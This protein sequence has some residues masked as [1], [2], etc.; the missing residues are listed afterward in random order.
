MCY[1]PCNIA[2]QPSETWHRLLALGTNF[3]PK[4][5]ARVSFQPETSEVPGADARLTEKESTTCDFPA[6]GFLLASRRASSLPLRF[7]KLAPLG[8]LFRVFLSWASFWLSSGA[9]AHLIHGRVA[10]SASPGLPEPGRPPPACRSSCPAPWR[11]ST[12]GKKKSRVHSRR[13]HGS[14]QEDRPMEEASACQSVRFCGKVGATKVL[15]RGRPVVLFLLRGYQKIS[16]EDLGG[17]FALCRFLLGTK[18]KTTISKM[19]SKGN[20]LVDD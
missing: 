15:W 10:R 11:R 6:L 1:A 19:C 9:L 17:G 2:Q 12:K 5:H 4:K 8:F 13:S 7:L 16:L 14:F 3:D 20:Q 18:R